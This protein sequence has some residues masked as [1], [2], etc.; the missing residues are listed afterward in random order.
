[1]KMKLQAGAIAM[2]MAFADH[3]AAQDVP[4]ETACLFFFEMY[5]PT[6]NVVGR[7]EWPSKVISLGEAEPGTKMAVPRYTLFSWPDGK[8]VSLAPADTT[9]EID[10]IAFRLSC[11][12][13]TQEE[14][15]LVLVLGPGAGTDTDFT[16]SNGA[17]KKMVPAAPAE[18]SMLMTPMQGLF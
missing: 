1:M 9:V 6:I 3:A 14:R 13:D 12:V 10:P 4:P 16:L 11:V 15:V 5:P 18:R 8:A 2:M 7:P 17:V